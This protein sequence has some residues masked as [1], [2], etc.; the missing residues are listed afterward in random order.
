MYSC[1]NCHKQVK[2][3][4]GH[5]KSF[6]DHDPDKE[7]GE[8]PKVQEKPIIKTLELDIKPKS[9]PQE[10]AEDAT[11]YHCIDCGYVGITRGQTGCPKCGARLDWS[12]L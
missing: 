3:L 10:K 1:P 5:Y 11:V 7:K 4:K 8:V 12:E 9:K 2:E 6:P